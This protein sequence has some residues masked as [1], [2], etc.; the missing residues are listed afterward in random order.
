MTRF[1]MN[2]KGFCRDE[3][4]AS[5]VEYSLLLGLVAMA[6]IIFITGVGDSVNT[7]WNA[8]DTTMGKAATA[9]ETAAAGG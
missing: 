3:R 9:A 6:A 8:T 2:L 1:N 7:I 4:G 5:L